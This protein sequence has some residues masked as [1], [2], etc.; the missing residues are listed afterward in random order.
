MREQNHTSH[1]S[2][3]CLSHVCIRYVEPTSCNTENKL[4][5][6]CYL[7]IET[8]NES[9]KLS[10]NMCGNWQITVGRLFWVV[11]GFY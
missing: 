4:I 8:V 7:M 5:E 10:F 1:T 9:K 6:Y 11:I 2:M 3:A